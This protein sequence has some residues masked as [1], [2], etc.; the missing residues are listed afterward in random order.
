MTNNALITGVA[1]Q[2]GYY[3]AK[4]L[5]SKG[6]RVFGQSRNAS[7]ARTILGS[8]PIALVSF[9][10]RSEKAWSQ[11]IEEHEL[12]EIY[13]MSGM[14]FIPSSWDNPTEV[15]ASNLEVT[16]HILE[17]IR[18]GSRTPR[19]AFACS[20]EIFGQPTSMSQNE[21]TA[22]RPMNPYGVTKAASFGLIES[23]R[24]RYGLFVCSGILFNHESPRRDPSFVTR[25]ITKAVAAI[26]Q[27]LQDCL[28]LGNLEV[29]RDWGFAE[30]YMDCMH[31]MLQN[32]S[33]EDFVIGSG[34]LTRLETF[35][36]MAFNRV[37]LNWK[38][39]VSIDPSF[40]RPNEP[41]SLVADASKAK[42]KLGW[43]ASTQVEELIE[44]MVDYD[45]ELLQLTKRI[46]A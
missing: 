7:N 14:S 28:M 8:Q 30:D 39:W 21:E 3:L 2:D 17:A 25:K 40:A 34:R 41:R 4:L 36:A 23:Y 6:Y 18:A 5:L 10:L 46:A 43:Q 45:L 11:A 33:P 12:D 38:D 32:D 1:G 37:G 44:M 42:E 15:I 26:S 9:D 16:V 13:H 24:K 29:S 20:S 22:M 27:G 35:V 19:L 31:R